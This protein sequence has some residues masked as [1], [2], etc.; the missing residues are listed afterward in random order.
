MQACDC[1]SG[2][3]LRHIH[4]HEEESRVL[5]VHVRATFIPCP[6][7]SSG[8]ASNLH[9]FPELR[10]RRDTPFAAAAAIRC[11]SVLQKEN[12]TRRQQEEELI[13]SLSANNNPYIK[14][15]ALNYFTV[16]NECAILVHR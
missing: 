6:C 12:K 2:F 16:V 10:R 9:S 13:R 14:S 8:R 7:S 11:Q 3:L 15:L 1:A 5:L 4:R